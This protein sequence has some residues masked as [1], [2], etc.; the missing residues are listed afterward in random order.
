VHGAE[1]VDIDDLV[2]EAKALL[3][4]EN[5]TPAVQLDGQCDQD[6][7]REQPDDEDN[8]QHDILDRLEDESQPDIGLPTS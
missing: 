7:K 6:Q 4:E 5:R 3:L 1:L 8:G 2:V